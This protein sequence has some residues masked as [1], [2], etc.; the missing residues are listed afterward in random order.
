MT[1]TR[2]DRVLI[3][4][5]DPAVRREIE[6][7][8]RR[9]HKYPIA[10]RQVST[11]NAAIQ[12]AR[13]HDPRI[14][15]LELGEERALTL[16]VARELRRI[17]RLLIGLFNP[18]VE[19]KDLAEA[20]FIRHAV[21]AGIGEFVPL[22]LSDTELAAALASVPETRT[23]AHE[24]RAIAFFGHQGGVG[25][26][27][28]AVNTALALSMAEPRRPV[29]LMDA[30]VQFGAVA[31]QLGMV[32]DRDLSDAIREIDQGVISP[33]PMAAPDVPLA[34]LASPSDTRAAELVTP[35]D[36]SRVLIEL[37]R[38]FQAIIIDT[39]PVLDMLTLS[40]LDLTETVIVVTDASAPTVAGAA[41]ALRMLADV[42]FDGN[43]VRLVVS[44]HRNAADALP[45]DVIAQELR[46]P[47][48]YVVPFLVPVSVGTHRGSPALFEKGAAQ[49]AD[50]VRKIAADVLRMG[51]RKA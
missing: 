25:T 31:F 30:N 50:A 49:F 21:R 47:V 35:E 39:A 32:P 29:A 18:L 36:V 34:V 12:A 40:V 44:K 45:I 16:S 1:E 15:F 14:V 10:V 17:D 3:V 13:E 11:P 27:T 28:L 51:G 33:L 48:D 22:P 7:A 6:S 42:G 26:T 20:E 19:E 4:H 43:R 23:G 8:V 37:R 9:T 2:T 41:R 24:G 46:R 38:R 5:P